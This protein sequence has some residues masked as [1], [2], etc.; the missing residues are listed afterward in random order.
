[1][2]KVNVWSLDRPADPEKDVR[3]VSDKGEEFEFT[4]RVANALR[5]ALVVDRANELIQK[6]ITGS[7]DTPPVA[8]PPID[9][10]PVEVGRTALQI[11]ASCEL[12][13][14]GENA[15]TAEE[16]IVLSAT[17]PE[18]VAGLFKEVRAMKGEHPGNSPEGNSAA[19]NQ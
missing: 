5:G 16:F 13:C 3:I 19:T 10:R 6:Y 14:T 1:M 18:V 17:R 11:A 9:G 8:F 12:A 15:Y 4:I 2:A 7:D